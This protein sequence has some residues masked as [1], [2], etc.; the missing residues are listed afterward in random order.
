MLWLVQLVTRSGGVVLDPFAGTGTT[1]EA[2]IT[3]GFRCVLAERDPVFVDLIRERL[4]K[5]IQPYL[6]A[7]RDDLP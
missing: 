2:C 3:G 1:A 4:R 7:A 6:P 5:P